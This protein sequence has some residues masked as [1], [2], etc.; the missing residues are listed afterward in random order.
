MSNRHKG[1]IA[2]QS[3]WN[4]R[5]SSKKTVWNMHFF[6]KRGMTIVCA[7]RMWFHRTPAQ[8]RV[9]QGEESWSVSDPHWCCPPGHLFCPQ[10]C[11]HLLCDTRWR[12]GHHCPFALDFLHKCPKRGYCSCSFCV[13]RTKVKPSKISE[14]MD[15]EFLMC[16]RYRIHTQGH[17]KDG[18]IP[19]S[20]EMTNNLLFIPCK[21]RATARSLANPLLR[22]D[23]DGRRGKK[24]S[25]EV[26]EYK[27]KNES[28]MSKERQ[29]NKT[30][31]M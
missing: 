3:E 10:P 17:K 28:T 27:T 21:L 7:Q 4:W 29:M 8:T 16:H 25:Y 19:P 18:F 13:L 24:S 14:L 31:V 12:F 30:W 20:I 2:L 15:W 9:R 11:K 23:E 22:R 26:S 1:M 6:W 5:V